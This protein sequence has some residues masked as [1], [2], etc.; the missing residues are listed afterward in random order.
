[1]PGLMIGVVGGKNVGIPGVL[2]VGK[3]GGER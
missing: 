2:G 3:V 1:M